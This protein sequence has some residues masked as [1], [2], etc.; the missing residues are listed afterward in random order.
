MLASGAG[1]ASRHSLG[2]A[3]FF[4]MLFATSLGVFFIP[5]LYNA[6]ESAVA[7]RQRAEAP[8]AKEAAS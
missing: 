3:V 5:T 7:R 6:I 2:T 4:G 1:A 8:A